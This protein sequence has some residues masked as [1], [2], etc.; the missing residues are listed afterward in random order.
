MFSPR[1][2]TER[3]AADDSSLQ[4]AMNVRIARSVLAATALTASLVFLVP[5]NNRLVA[6][7]FYAPTLALLVAALATAR[8]GWP[9]APGHLLLLTGWTTV[10]LAFA[11]SDCSMASAVSYVPVVMIAS[12]TLGVREGIA[13]AAF[14]STTAGIV[15][16]LGATGHL[17]HAAI[18]ST[19]FF[20]WVSLNYAL[21]VVAMLHGYVL[22]AAHAALRRQRDALAARAE[23]QS[24]AERRAQLAEA[25]AHLAAH[26]L[27]VDGLRGLLPS[28][29]RAVRELLGGDVLLLVEQGGGTARWSLD[30]QGDVTVQALAHDAVTFDDDRDVRACT[31]AECASLA[32]D[33]PARCFTVQGPLHARARLVVTLPRDGDPGALADTFLKTLAAMLGGVWARAHAH[34]RALRAQRLELLG[35]LT[36]GVIHDIRNVLTAV[37]AASWELR[38]RHGQNAHDAAALDDLDATVTRAAG[39]AKRLL[40]VARTQSEVARCVDLA[41]VVRENTPMLRRVVGAH[42]R[43]EGDDLAETPVWADPGALEQVILNLVVNARDAMPDGGVITLRTRVDGDRCELS[44]Q[45]TGRG[46][47]EDTARRA[48]EPF[49]TTRADGTGLGLATVAELVARCH[50]SAH[51]DSA[52]GAGT[53]VTVRL[54]RHTSAAS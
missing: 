46:M 33:G 21:A 4:T 2:S 16:A 12:S 14:C 43:I 44:V 22:H 51:I 6:A 41:D 11:L 52:P 30:A 48:F 38:E 39:I 13:T 20:S 49:F 45:D 7:A 50:G 3:L 40:A 54:P 37:Q 9:R 1:A 35:Q 42:V 47:S 26:T 31:A 5:G 10:T 27:T 29:G 18:P 19:R 8:R 28:A 53:T 34:D 36:G 15:Y 25:V 32:L 17:P 23:A 24:L